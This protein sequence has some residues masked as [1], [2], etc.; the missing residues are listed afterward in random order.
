MYPPAESVRKPANSVCSITSCN[1][2]LQTCTF[3][4]RV[5]KSSTEVAAVIP[6]AQLLPVHGGHHNDLFRMWRV[7]SQ[8]G[9][10]RR[11]FAVCSGGAKA[12]R[13]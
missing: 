3:P 8:T 5:L 11:R 6:A 12:A 10:F 7:R 4:A 1:P 9:A 13:L 2:T